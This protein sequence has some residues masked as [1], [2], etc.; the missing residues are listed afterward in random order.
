M[1]RSVWILPDPCRHKVHLTVY[2]LLQVLSRADMIL[3]QGPQLWII[4]N[5]S[6]CINQG[7]SWCGS[8]LDEQGSSTRFLDSLRWAWIHWSRQHLVYCT[9]PKAVSFPEILTGNI[10]WWV[11]SL[12]YMVRIITKYGFM[13]L[14]AL[15]SPWRAN[16]NSSTIGGTSAQSMHHLGI[17]ET[18]SPLFPW[19]LWQLLLLRPWWNMFTTH[20]GWAWVHQ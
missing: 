8:K 19:L 7:F 2:H 9:I 18:S 10:C 14:V 17:S 5:K 1:I 13:H 3:I 12:L 6:M 4:W 11:P 16:T 20:Y 15:K